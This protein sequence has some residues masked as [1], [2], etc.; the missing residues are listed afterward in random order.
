MTIDC[1]QTDAVTLYKT[2]TSVVIP[3]PIAWVGSQDAEGVHNLAPFSF[4]N[5]ISHDPPHIMISCVN[6]KGNL[7]DTARNI[8]S[9]KQFTV[10]LVTRPLLEKM[11]TTAATI[12][13]NECEFEL[14]GLT[15]LPGEYV[16][17]PRVAESQVQFEC[18]LAKDFTLTGATGGATVLIGKIEKIHLNDVIHDGTGRIDAE[19][20]LAVGKL[21]KHN[22]YTPE[23]KFGLS[24]PK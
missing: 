14:A 11:N 20:Y 18:T 19:K 12:P 17:A 1:A 15:P 23:G 2:L 21:E 3:R 13:A 5:V 8:L 6:P 22:Y 4:F 9:Q 7:K 24:R 10:N 16:N